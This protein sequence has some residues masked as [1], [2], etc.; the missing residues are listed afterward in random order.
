[1]V[2]SHYQY[3]RQRAGSAHPGDEQERKV[4][5]FDLLERTIPFVLAGARGARW[6]TEQIGSLCDC[7]GHSR[8][9]CVFDLAHGGRLT[10]GQFLDVACGR[11]AKWS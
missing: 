7:A 11:F 5:I 4:A 8:Q 6:C 1:M 2:D 3:R 10:G 9:R